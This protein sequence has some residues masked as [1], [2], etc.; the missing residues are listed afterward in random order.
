MNALV[1]SRNV[2]DAAALV[3]MAL[4]YAVSG[5]SLKDVAALAKAI[6][7][8]QITGPGLFYRLRQW[9]LTTLPSLAALPPGPHRQKL[10]QPSSPLSPWGCELP[11]SFLF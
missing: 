11:P 6:D 1:R 3:R 2:P 8:A 9:L 7:L 4:V 10:V 5:W